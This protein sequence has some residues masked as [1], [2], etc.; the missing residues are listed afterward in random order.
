MEDLYSILW[1]E[2]TATKEEIKKA[3]RKLA[4]Q[5]H[6]DRNAWDKE[7][8][9]KFKKIN[10][11]YEIL[12][13]DEKR[14]SYDMFWS[15]SGAGN[16]FE[17]GF[18]WVDVDLWDI[19]DSFFGWWFS[20]E[21]R[22]RRSESPGENLQ[23]NLDIDLKTS[24][25]WWK[26]KIEFNKKETCKTCNGEW[27]KGKKTCPRCNWKWQVISVTQSIFWTIQQ[28]SICPDCRGSG[29]VFEEVCSECHWEKRVLIKKEITIDIPAW[30][31][32]GMVIKINGEWNDWIW[33][34]AKWDLY[35]KFGVPDEEK[36][37]KRDGYNLHY[38]IEVEIPEAVLWARKEVNIPIIW[39]R[40]IEVKAW[41]QNANIIKIAN[42][43]VKHIDSDRKWDLFIEITIKIPKKLTKN[44]KRLYE[45]LAKERN[46]E[47]LSDKWVFEK[48]FG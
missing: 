47:V 26:E 6:P 11:A 22:R 2:K 7:S 19:F 20:S 45:W 43:W 8:E 21:T 5:H 39:K 9:E 25:F 28:T 10:T 40:K 34:K 12:S 37:L 44:E 36:W 30:I 35:I 27:W 3:Y 1:V 15:T 29:E 23:Y 46:I 32:D 13:D 16:P 38:N 24:I 4:M 48:I 31:D 41:T 42:D 33:T 18:S 17:W 14:R